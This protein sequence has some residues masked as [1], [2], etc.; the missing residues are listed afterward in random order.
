MRSSHRR[1]MEK[2]PK[3]H[4]RVEVAGLGSGGV[5]W[6]RRGSGHAMR[7]KRSAK[8][9]RER[10]CAG[11]VKAETAS[12]RQPTVDPRLTCHMP[13]ADPSP[14]TVILLGPATSPD[15]A[16]PSLC[17]TLLLLAFACT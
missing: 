10:R 14:F 9:N 16:L 2:P 12:T 4:R 17:G 5:L 13:V 3:L 1:A 8:F 11:S 7:P 6:R 15:F